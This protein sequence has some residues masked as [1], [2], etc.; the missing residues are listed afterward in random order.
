MDQIAAARLMGRASLSRLRARPALRLRSFP[1][2]GIVR[3]AGGGC[4]RQP[5]ARALRPVPGPA[6]RTIL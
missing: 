2:D 6:C 4:R 5:A 3:L 1:M